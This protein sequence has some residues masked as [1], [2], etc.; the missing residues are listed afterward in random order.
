M[1][2]EIYESIFDTILQNNNTTSPYDNPMYVEY[3]KLNQS[4]QNRWM[5][6][7]VITPEISTYIASI[8]K[9]Q[10][11]V[12][13]TEPWCGDAAHCVPFI[14]KIAQGN[15]LIH[16]DIQL[17]DSN[18]SEIENYLTNGGKSIPILIARDDQKRDL[19]VW[20]P[21]PS[22]CTVLVN[23]LKAQNTSMEE[24]KVALQQWYNSNQG[25]AI[26]EDLLEQLTRLNQ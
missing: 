15:P 3:V 14:V 7:G 11:W 6:K 2:F 16:L 26:Q 20:G 23:Q 22:E 13:I 25:K 24:Q 10:T 19:F 9:P 4:R 17:R 12:I 1:T 21:R 18:E 8:T 5:K